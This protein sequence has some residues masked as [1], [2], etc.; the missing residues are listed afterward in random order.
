[1]IVT[2]D[3]YDSFFHVPLKEMLLKAEKIEKK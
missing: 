3:Q 1:M 2:I